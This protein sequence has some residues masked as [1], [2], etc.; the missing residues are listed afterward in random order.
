MPI[1]LI[2]GKQDPVIGKNKGYNQTIKDLNRQGFDNLKHVEFDNM[3]HEILNEDA[4]DLVYKEIE[5]FL[6]E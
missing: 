5:I 4:K 6:G 3:R 1:L 2:N